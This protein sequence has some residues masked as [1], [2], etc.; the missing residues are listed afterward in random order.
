MRIA[1]GTARPRNDKGF[2]RDT[3]ERADRVVLPYGWV[4]SSVVGR[5]DVGI[6]PY[7]PFTDS[8]S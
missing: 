7:A 1:T 8:I 2:A 3:V 6:V 5:D 4:A